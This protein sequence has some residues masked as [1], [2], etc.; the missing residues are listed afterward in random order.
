MNE[1]LSKIVEAARKLG[2]DVDELEA[3]RWL[4]A[5]A[6]AP[7]GGDVV[8]DVRAGVYGHRVSMLD[9]SPVELA[10]FRRIGEI[11]GFEDRVGVETALALS[12]SAAQSKIQTHPGDAD[13]FERINIHAPSREAACRILAEVMRDKALA[14][15]RGDGYR[16]IEV[17]FGSAPFDIV[18][19]GETRRAGS[20]LS[21]RPEQVETGSIAGIRADGSAVEISWQEAS[22]NPGWCKLDWVVAD[23]VHGTLANASNMLDVTWEQPD[24]AIIPLDGHLDGYFQEVYLEAESIP[25]FSKVVRQASADA[26][27]SYVE[28]LEREVAKY[29]TKDLNYGKAAKR[30]YNVFRLTGRYVDA[31]YLRELFDGPAAMLYQVWSLLRTIDDAFSASEPTT[32]GDAEANADALIATVTEALEGPEETEIVGLLLELRT[33]LGEADQSQG[34]TADLDAIRARVINLVNSFFHDRLVGVPSIA[35]YIAEVRGPDGSAPN[36]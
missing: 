6:A 14:T 31:A 34:L 24:G 27:D 36:G 11:V 5:I 28:Q 29:L 30:M 4:T 12:G 3:S 17:K 7:E 21:W 19:D 16:L 9:F 22:S 1:E 2:V 8:V 23:P 35:S 25:I 32:L 10:H 20:A 26:L 33:R 13:Y 18:V 15:R